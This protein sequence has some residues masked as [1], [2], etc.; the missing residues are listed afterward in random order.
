LSIY[1]RL[2]LAKPGCYDKKETC[3]IG[4]GIDP[5]KTGWVSPTQTISHN[6]PIIDAALEEYRR[7]YYGY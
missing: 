5:L 1:G 3:L 2:F 7:D 6:S 4:G